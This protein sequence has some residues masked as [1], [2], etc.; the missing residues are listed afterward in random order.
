MTREITTLLPIA[1][2][3]FL[4]PAMAESI[5]STDFTN[6][7]VSGKTAGNLNWTTNGVAD[8]GDLT[9]VAEAPQ[10]SSGSSDAL[11]DTGDS[12]GHFAP[13]RNI[14]NEGAWSVSIPLVL[15]GP[16]LELSEVTLDWRHFNNS[17]NYQTADRSADWTATLTGSAT[18]LI[19]STT[20]TGVSGLSGTCQLS[21]SSTLTLD[22][23]ETYTLK[24]HVVGTN[25]PSGGNNTAL[26]AI[27]IGSSEPAEPDT[28][29]NILFLMADDQRS[30]TLG[31]YGHPVVQTP[32]IDNLAAQGVRFTNAFVT[33]PICAASRASVLTGV[34]E[35]THGYTFGMD[36]VPSQLDAL[37]YPKLL[38]ASGYRTGF[39]GKYGVSM[40][41][42]A[43]SHFDSVQQVAGYATSTPYFILQDD[44]SYRHST[45]V[46]ADKA[47]EFI[48]STTPGQPFCLSVSFN[49]PHARDGATVAEESYPW[50]SSS[51]GL[52][53]TGE[54]P[55]QGLNE[56]WFESQPAFVQ[57]SINRNRFNW[58]WNTAEKYDSHLRAHLRMITG[59]DT[60]VGNILATLESEGLA[61]NTIIIYTADNGLFLGARGFAGKWNHYEQA[62][63][64]PLIVYDPRLPEQS[65]GRVESA[66]A[67]N[68]DFSPTFLDWAD[69]PPHAYCQG[70]SLVPVIEDRSETTRADFFCEHHM[71]TNSTIPKWRGVRDQRYVYACYYEEDYE[72]LHDIQTDPDQWVNLALDPSYQEVLE[73]MRERCDAYQA[74]FQ[75]RESVAAGETLV[76]DSE[77]DGLP[78]YWETKHFGTLTRNGLADADGDGSSDLSE[79]LA[80]TDPNDAGSRPMLRID[81]DLTLAYSPYM[82]GRILT[83][84]HSADPAGEAAWSAAPLSAGYDGSLLEFDA[85]ATGASTGFYRM[86]ITDPL[87]K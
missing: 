31:C 19:D 69:E 14:D 45:D 28:R 56:S 48:E 46:C 37:S 82:P 21:F 59:I 64:V 39:I 15:T 2:L 51:D 54:L 22:D 49:A 6:R 70:V 12:A 74:V 16:Q 5:A 83:L 61:D 63:R 87:G 57:N 10:Q 72:Y 84:E 75:T 65:R 17:G 38:G 44:G 85:P 25:Y 71:A 3:L 86:R 78:D 24:I 50:P 73:Q 81:P 62:L 77:P 79:A 60:A 32:V 55:D 34:T 33:T 20:A 35:R 4:A 23:S 27:S 30:D 36:A 80:G 1:S 76:V 8:P 41:T 43:A 53:L 9:W 68:I 42:T 26:D 58:R 18:G 66:I 29:P 47:I 67:L 40:A 7:T 52:Y 11:F 13:D